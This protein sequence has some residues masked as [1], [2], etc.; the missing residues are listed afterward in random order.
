[1]RTTLDLN[2]TLLAQARVRA[3]QERT[4]LTRLIEEGLALRLRPP[5][6]HPPDRH[7]DLQVYAGQGGLAPAVAD[8]LT[9]RAL[10]D[11]T[12]EVAE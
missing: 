2:E 6:S 11:A 9:H 8:S 7:V 4:T 5:A 3:A 12:D 1:M 10:L